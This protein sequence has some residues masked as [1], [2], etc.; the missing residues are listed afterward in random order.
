M[1]GLT[2][3]A[4]GRMRIDEVGHPIMREQA[5][6]GGELH[7]LP[8]FGGLHIAADAASDMRSAFPGLYAQAYRH[9]LRAL[10]AFRGPLLQQQRFAPAVRQ[11][12]AVRAGDGVVAGPELA[13][14]DAIRVGGIALAPRGEAARPPIP[15]RVDPDFV[16]REM[17]RQLHLAAIGDAALKRIGAL[18]NAADISVDIPR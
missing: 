10:P 17:Q 3:D 6:T 4:D 9:V 2:G 8:P 14:E 11:L 18:E 1:A 13:E 12:L 15:E 5:V 7:P 16:L